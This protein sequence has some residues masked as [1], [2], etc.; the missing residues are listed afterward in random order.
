MTPQKKN[1]PPKKKTNKKNKTKQNKNKKQIKS[2][3]SFLIVEVKNPKFSSFGDSTKNT[4]T[5]S[6]LSKKKN[7]E[8]S[9]NLHS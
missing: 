2:I 9:S 4:L 1:P 7:M 8:W 3:S 5:V 6:P